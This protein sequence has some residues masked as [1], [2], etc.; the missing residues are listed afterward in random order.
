MINAIYKHLET[1]NRLIN[2][3]MGG[4]KKIILRKNVAKGDL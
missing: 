2:S 3:N 4:F 1:I